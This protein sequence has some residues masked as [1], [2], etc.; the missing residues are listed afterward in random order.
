M[1]TVSDLFEQYIGTK[2][3]NGI[4]ATI[5]K[6]FYGCKEVVHAPWC[7][8]SMS[9]ML[10]E[11]GLLD[12]IGKRQDN[13]Y[14]LMKECESAAKRGVGTFYYRSNI[15]TNMNILRGTIVFI[16]NSDPPMT[17]ESSK[18]VTSVYENLKWKG[19]G[20]WKGLG[21]NQ[22][23]MIRVSQYVQAKI[24]AIYIPPYSEEPKHQTL[25]KGDKGSDVSELQSLLN[26]LGY[27]DGSDAMLA[28]DGSFGRRTEE[29]V[30]NFQRINGLGVDGVCG[31]KTWAKLDEHPHAPL[32]KVKV[33]IDLY[34]RRGPSTKYPALKVL[35]EGY[36]DYYT[37]EK[38][39]WI[40]LI[41]ANGWVNKN[42]VAVIE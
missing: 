14:R 34:C 17:F 12:K 26:E 13:V 9:Y 3:Y 28:V 38:D 4:V 39:G 32:Y 33:K 41:G 27:R 35:K 1:K 16:L 40:L 37:N 19:S 24:Y 20:N 29:A 42:Y 23:D 2:E 5:Q 25:R 36:V 10:N 6:W 30:K 15:P 8:T 21:G 11:L 22:S 18:H 7:S 31:P